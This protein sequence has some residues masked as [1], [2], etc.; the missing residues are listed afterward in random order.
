M[1]KILLFLFTLGTIAQPLMAIT[2]QAE[3]FLEKSQVNGTDAAIFTFYKT[4]NLIVQQDVF[5]SGSW[6]EQET[7]L[8]LENVELALSKKRFSF[9]EPEKNGITYFDIAFVKDAKGK[10]KAAPANID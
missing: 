10:I 6:S 4:G 2:V 7:Y 1:K 9:I 5:Y 8:L 3:H